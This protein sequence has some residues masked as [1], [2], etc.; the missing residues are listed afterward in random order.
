MASINILNLG[1]GGTKCYQQ[2]LFLEKWC[3]E[4]GIAQ[5]KIYTIFNNISA[6]SGGAVLAC[7]IAIGTPLSVIKD[8][9]LNEAQ[10]IFTIRSAQDLLEGSIN[11]S[12]PSN[13][14]NLAQKV[15]F[16]LANE[17]WYKSV[18]ELSNY[19]NA[20]LKTTLDSFF[21]NM[22]MGDLQ[23]KVLI[24]ALQENTSSAVFFSNINRPYLYGQNEKLVDVIMAT[25]SVPVMLPSYSFKSN[26]YSDGGLVTANPLRTFKTILQAENPTIRRFNMMAINAGLGAYGIEGVPNTTVETSISQLYGL[27]EKSYS[28][29]QVTTDLELQIESQYTLNQTNVYNYNPQLPPEVY[30]SDG[31]TSTT[32]FWEF[33]EGVVDSKW[34]EDLVKIR[35]FNNRLF[36]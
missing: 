1:P 12:I 3:A 20:R 27:F 28:F 24:P 34:N 9:F 31:D 26:I 18:S 29:S 5:D 16:I 25:S 22:T 2:I 17:P 14:P 7:A 6:V 21:G 15:A 8:F 33:L 19:G 30:G 10:W 36:A 23:C 13:K 35:D 4:T 32:S 11:A